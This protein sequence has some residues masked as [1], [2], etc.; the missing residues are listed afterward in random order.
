[1][2]SKD[3]SNHNGARTLTVVERLVGIIYNV[4]H[5]LTFHAE[6]Y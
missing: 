6:S 4:Y 1:M 2:T 5:L 3:F